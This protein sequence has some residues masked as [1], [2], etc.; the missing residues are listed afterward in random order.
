MKLINYHGERRDNK[1]K[2]VCLKL[3]TGYIILA[4]ARIDNWDNGTEIRFLEIMEY[5]HLPS[6]WRY[7]AVSRKIEQLYYIHT[8]YYS[9]IISSNF[10]AE[11][12][13]LTPPC[14]LGDLNLLKTLL[15]IQDCIVFLK[16]SVASM[17]LSNRGLLQ[18]T[19]LRV[20]KYAVTFIHNTIWYVPK[21][22]VSLSDYKGEN[23][24][25]FTN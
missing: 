7:I 24:F 9:I 4:I 5:K 23:S 22:M 20:I 11:L 1:I 14:W 15:H 12:R 6:Q 13:Q 3:C 8:F 18:S 16:R 17:W 25:L 2:V 21:Y 19:N 10:K